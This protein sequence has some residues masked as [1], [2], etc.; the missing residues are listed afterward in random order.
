MTEHHFNTDIAAKVGLNAAV[1]YN[2][3]QFW[4]TK[5]EANGRNFHDGKY[6]VY[7][8]TEAWGILFPY[9][10]TSQIRTALDKLI[11]SDLIE[12]G[13]YN[14]DARDRTKWFACICQKSQISFAK[15]RQPLPDSKQQIVN[16]I[17]LFGKKPLSKPNNKLNYEEIR[18]RLL[19]VFPKRTNPSGKASDLKAL[20]AALDKTTEDELAR[21]VKVY[22]DSRKGQDINFN[23]GF[24]P[25][26]NGGSYETI[27]PGVPVSASGLTKSQEHAL[28]QEL[29]PDLRERMKCHFLK[30]E[31]K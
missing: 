19:S 25:W 8:S 13:R 2:N 11:K 3:I 31:V 18:I 9:L 22:A 27:G 5:N 28:R 21:A 12:T 1:I 10:S 26:L 7:N 14:K 16:S 6:W 15:N 20:K 24:A 30:G 17:D 29:D 4:V 23:K